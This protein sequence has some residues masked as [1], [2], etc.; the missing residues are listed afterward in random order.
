MHKRWVSWAAVSSLPQ[1]KK[2]SNEQQ[3]DVNRQHATKHGGEIVRELVVPGESRSIV[4][5]EQAAER[6][7]AYAELRRLIEQRAFDVLVYLD[8]SR[9][10]RKASLSMSVIELCHEAGI[11]TYETDNPPANLDK[12][13][14]YDDALVGA[15]KSVSAQQ[16]IIKFM[17]RSSA[18]KIG[19]AKAGKMQAGVPFGYAVVYVPKG[20]KTEPEYSVNETQAATVRRIFAEYLRGRGQLSIAEGLNADGI[21]TPD[22]TG[23]WGKSNVRHIIARVWTYAGYA[24]VNRNSRRGRP[25][26]RARGTWPPL[27]DDATARQVD[28]ER[29]A[30]VKNRH[31][32]DTHTLLSGICVCAECGRNMHVTYQRDRGKDYQYFY[33]RCRGYHRSIDISHKRVLQFLRDAMTALNGVNLDDLE[34]DDNAAQLQGRMAELA[35]SLERT[36]AQLRAVDSRYFDGTLDE[37]RYTYQVRRL[38]AQQAATTAEIERLQQELDDEAARGTR[39]QRLHDAQAIGLA[40]LDNPDVTAANAWL[41]RCIRVYVGRSGIESAHWL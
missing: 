23:A 7:E 22:G 15:I 29:A 34:D 12:P 38:T 5:L 25:Y 41:R 9:L 32:S 33:L 13:A 20:A 35:A 8:R 37:E 16:E 14:G 11:I 6:I 19:R 24:E 18:G 2:I 10:G 21:S 27:I 31:L 40:M 3:L 17:A 1:A 26:H 28:D 39:R 4:L 30:R 36:A